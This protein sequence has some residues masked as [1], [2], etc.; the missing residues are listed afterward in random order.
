MSDTFVLVIKVLASL[1][2]LYMCL[3]PSTSIYR[4]H[5]KRTTGPASAVPLVALWGCNHLW[6][7]Y[8]YV[9][10]NVFPLMITYIVGDI[11][12]ILF[13]TVFCV[14][15]PNRRFVLKTTAAMFLINAAVTI[16]VVLAKRGVIHQSVNQRNLVMGCIAIASSIFLYASP[17]ATIKHVIRTKS[18]ASIMFSMVMVGIVN[19]SLWIIYGFLISDA[20]LVV[21]TLINV[22]IGL[23]QLALYI[24]YHPKRQK[25]GAPTAPSTAVIPESSALPVTMTPVTPIE[26]TAGHSE[27]ALHAVVI[28]GGSYL[29]IQTP[30]SHLPPR[31][32]AMT[33]A[34]Q[35]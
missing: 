21:P 15:A 25:A 20:F 34:A 31:E 26:P 17:F 33:N 14:Y 7:L 16:Y 4:I 10:D 18:S 11:T 35:S 32:V 9:T 24:V 6:M 29:E 30:T 1:S 22:V 19:N 23:V 3:S 13:I 27:V 28:E 12:S 2:A 5:K 8:G